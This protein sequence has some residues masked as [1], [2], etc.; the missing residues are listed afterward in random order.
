MVA[1]QP[2][3]LAAGLRTARCRRESL[4]RRGRAWASWPGSP[5]PRMPLRCT[6]AR[7]ICPGSAIVLTAGAPPRSRPPP[8]AG[9]HG[10]GEITS[11]AAPESTISSTSRL[12]LR[13][14]EAG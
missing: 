7:D 11:P 6:D 14:T 8:L 10:P 1:A 4:R 12:S 3:I 5:R 2:E 9:V 13:T